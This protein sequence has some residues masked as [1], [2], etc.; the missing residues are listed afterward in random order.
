MN[1]DYFFSVLIL[2][3]FEIAGLHNRL[4]NKFLNLGVFF[5]F[6]TSCFQFHLI[7][8]C[9]ENKCLLKQNCSVVGVVIFLVLDAEGR[10]AA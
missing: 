6:F 10:E 7:M 1:R 2:K 3:V 4:K 5:F 9:S 8:N